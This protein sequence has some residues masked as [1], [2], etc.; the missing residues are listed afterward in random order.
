MPSGIQNWSQTAGS[1]SNADSAINWAEGQAPSSVNDSSRGMMKVLRDWNVDLGGITTTGSST[2]YAVTTARNFAA[3][4]V[5][6]MDG[7]IIVIKP[8][9]TS[10]AN[11]TLAVDGLTARQIRSATGVNVAAGA[12]VTGTPY[13]LIYIHATT[14]F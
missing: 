2:A 12:L 8:H 14:E 1:N 6:T 11:P 3:S 5:A 7:Q 9:T 10:G 13:M 4:G